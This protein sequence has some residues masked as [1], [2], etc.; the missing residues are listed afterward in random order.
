MGDKMG[1]LAAYEI[2]H[3]AHLVKRQARP[4]RW[5]HAHADTWE[6]VPNKR[7]TGGGKRPLQGFRSKK[8][9]V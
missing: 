5:G 9:A 6:A 2:L 1:G 7:I 8:R 4:P 3:V